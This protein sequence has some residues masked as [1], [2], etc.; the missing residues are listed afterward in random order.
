[1]FC[2]PARIKILVYPMH[3]NVMRENQ[4]PPFANALGRN[5]TILSI[6]NLPP[7]P[8]KALTSMKKAFEGDVP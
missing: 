2:K 7:V 5:K 1:M 3:V 8:T 6:Q 4:R